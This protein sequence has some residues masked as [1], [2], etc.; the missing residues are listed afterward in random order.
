MQLPPGPARTSRA[1]SDLD[2]HVLARHHQF[3]AAQKRY[4][5]AAFGHGEVVERLAGQRAVVRRRDRRER[6][7]AVAQVEQ[8]DEV[9]ER[10][11]FFDE[12]GDDLRRV[13]G[14]VHAPAAVV[15]PAVARVA[16]R[17]DDPLHLE[18]VLGQEA[19]D[20]VVLVVPGGRDEDVG[21][22]DAG[23]EQDRRLVD[24]AAQHA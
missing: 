1:S 24:V 9:G 5:V 21:A 18:L 2:A 13:D 12:A 20:E 11:L 17:A 22:V 6:D 4:R 16:H 8:A 23:V 19:A 3:V 15:Q 14:H 10:R 7:F